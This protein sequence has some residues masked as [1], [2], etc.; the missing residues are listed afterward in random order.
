MKYPISILF[1]LFFFNSCDRD[2][3]LKKDKSNALKDYISMQ[4]PK[5]QL[6]LNDFI[7]Y[8]NMPKF[9]SL[10]NLSLLH[11]NALNEGANLSLKKYFKNLSIPDTSIV[12]NKKYLDLAY[13]DIDFLP[14]TILDFNEIEYL[15]LRSN[16]LKG[17]HKK[18]DQLQKLKKIDLSSNGW[19]DL[20]H[21]IQYLKNLRSIDL[22][23]NQLKKVPDVLSELDSIR[24]IDL[25]NFHPSAA[26][27]GNQIEYI[28][29]RLIKIKHLQRLF[30]DHLPLK[31]IPSFLGEIESLKVLSIRSCT[32]LNIFQVIEKLSEATNIEVLDISFLGLNRLPRNISKLSHLKVLI[33]HEEK[34]R[35]ATYIEEELS[36]LLP[37]TKIY[38]GKT[39]MMTP[40]LRGN[41]LS[42][43]LGNN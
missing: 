1:L 17:F 16:Q 36:L 43:I 12:Y 4:M 31:E 40:L 24:H 27:F 30:L 25:G 22:R 42:T 41:K 35:N 21:S 3:D 2:Q 7:Y 32:D 6:K 19:N 28:S 8:F 20:P 38:Y 26:Q 18:F 11:M 13:M 15:N 14:K 37:Y 5:D 34:K 23:D 29:R 39:K 10:S 33:W 9:G